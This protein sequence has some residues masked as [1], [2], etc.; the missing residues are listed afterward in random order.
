[1]ATSSNDD[2]VAGAPRTEGAVAG[3]SAK[4]EEILALQSEVSSLRGELASLKGQMKDMTSELSDALQQMGKESPT[5]AARTGNGVA[6]G[7]GDGGA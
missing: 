4:D 7:R 6:R 2:I 1:M 3:Q 5:A